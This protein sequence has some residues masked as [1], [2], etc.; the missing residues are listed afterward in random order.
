MLFMLVFSIMAIANCSVGSY[1]GGSPKL[2]IEPGKINE[3]RHWHTATKLLDGKI[4]IAGGFGNRFKVLKAVEIYDPVSGEWEKVADMNFPRAEHSA[5]LLQDGRILV[6]GGRDENYAPTFSTEIFDPKLGVWEIYE[7][8]ARQRHKHISI[9]QSDGSVIIIAGSGPS[10]SLSDVELIDPINDRLEV[11]SSTL[12]EHSDHAAIS[13]GD[14]RI[15][16]SGGV[17]ILDEVVTSVGAEIYDVTTNTWAK[18]SIQSRRTSAHTLTLLNDGRVIQIGGF[19]GGSSDN[20]T[21]LYDSKTDEWLEGPVMNNTRM[22]HTASL[23]DD[24]RVIAIGGTSRSGNMSHSEIYD[25]ETQMWMASGQMVEPR[26]SHTATVL[27]DGKVLVVGGTNTNN[28]ICEIYDPET[29]TWN[30]SIVETQ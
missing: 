25:P 17:R 23:L 18:T 26:A 6:T 2:A 20:R 8:M 10:R 12:E 24:G 29:G 9:V 15:F 11:L 27:D 22:L 5:A 28:G 4:L 1:F 21:E 13:L 19:S 16:V 30:S 14:G 3:D 7:D